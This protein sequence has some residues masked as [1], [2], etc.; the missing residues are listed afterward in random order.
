MK[1]FNGSW[2]Q[3]LALALPLLAVGCGAVKERQV[4][5]VPPSYIEAQTASLEELITLI[6]DKYSGYRSITVSKFDV[7]FTG[8][9]IEEGYLEKYRK[10]KGYLVAQNPDSI[11]VNILNPLTNSSV[12]VMASVDEEFRIWIPS[13]NQFVTG[14]TDQM[15]EVENPVYNVRPTHII[16]GILIEPVPID[17]PS[18]RCHLEEEQDGLY[19]YY[20]IGIFRFREDS[21]FLE[22]E[23]KIWIERSKMA[24][25]R[26]Q[27]YQAGKVISVVTYSNP[28]P[29]GQKM[30]NSNVAI[31]R[32]V[33][34][35]SISFSIETDGV[36]LN[37]ELK[38][39]A[40]ELEQPSGSELIRVEE[41]TR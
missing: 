35:Y 13:K 34:R 19:K 11:F 15:P 14:R 1:L 26:Q 32:P 9:S 23:R 10:A 40:F 41:N 18:I 16:D 25:S 2:I 5:S 12:L 22:M 28:V 4:I 31:E 36:R 39:N 33:E 7:E 29:V 8:G 6:N 24:L 17:Q 21:P 37:R 20:V 3:I 30:V 38:T 27:Y